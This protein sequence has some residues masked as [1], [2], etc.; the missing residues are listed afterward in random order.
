M[1]LWNTMPPIMALQLKPEI[2]Q[3]RFPTFTAAQWFVTYSLPLELWAL[4]A[5]GKK[6]AYF[7]FYMKMSTLIHVYRDIQYNV[8]IYI[9]FSYPL[10]MLKILI[11]LL[12]QY[13]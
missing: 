4:D 12:W 10:Q 7:F 1:S 13:I 8:N 2:P 9:F 3:I 11:S 5:M 6:F